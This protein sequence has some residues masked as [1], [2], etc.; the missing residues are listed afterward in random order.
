ML[1]VGRV[2]EGG[3]LVQRMVMIF[4][5]TVCVELRQVLVGALAE[6]VLLV[7]AVA[8]ARKLDQLLLRLPNRRH[9]RLRLQLR[10]VLALS[11]ASPVEDVDRN[12][13]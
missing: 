13:V 1:R 11:V 4:S 10:R 2:D 8:L 12:Q 7:F 5:L 6:R 3:L 9:L